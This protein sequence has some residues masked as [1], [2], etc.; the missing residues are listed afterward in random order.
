MIAVAA[1]GCGGSGGPIDGTWRSQKTTCDANDVTAMSA[2]F[3]L[4]I[5]N[6]TGTFVLN[7]SASCTATIQEAYGYPED[8]QFQITPTSVSCAPNSGCRAA[9]GADCIP[10]PGPTLF[11]YSKSGS[12]LTFTQTAKGPPADM[13]A[14]GKPLV[15]VMTGP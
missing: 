8:G 11:G 13:C 15:Y 12:S 4:N 14:A 2:P 10:L 1:L 6:Q 3:T 9:I 5:T 7:F